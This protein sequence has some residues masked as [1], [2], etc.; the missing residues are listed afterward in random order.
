MRTATF[1]IVSAIVFGIADLILNSWLGSGGFGWNIRTGIWIGG[2][3]IVG[4]L[5]GFVLNHFNANLLAFRKIRGRDVLD[6]ERYESDKIDHGMITLHPQK[7][8]E[9]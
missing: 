2:G 1:A 9:V 5:L 4:L 8:R 6:E 3:L 7:E